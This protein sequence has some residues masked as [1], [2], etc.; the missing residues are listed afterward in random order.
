MAD[1]GVEHKV[2]LLGDDEAGAFDVVMDE[3]RVLRVTN[4]AGE[5][6]ADD[7]FVNEVNVTPREGGVKKLDE[8]GVVGFGDVGNV[9]LEVGE[10]DGKARFALEDDGVF[11]SKRAAPRRGGSEALKDLREGTEEEVVDG[12]V[13]VAKNDSGEEGVGGIWVWV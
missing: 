5:A 1:F 6:S 11:G 2:V 4:I 8:G 7:E 3:A 13:D 12:I 10:R 9:A